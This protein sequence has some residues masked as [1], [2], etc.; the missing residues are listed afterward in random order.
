VAYTCNPSYSGGRVQEN[1]RSKPDRLQ[2]SILKKKKKNPSQKK[3]W[4]SG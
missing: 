4:Q 3:G 1:H 2:D